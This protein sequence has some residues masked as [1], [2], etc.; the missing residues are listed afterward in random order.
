MPISLALI[1]SLVIAG[2]LLL[3]AEVCVPGM[4]LGIIGFLILAASVALVFAQYGV[5]TGL[6]SA[7]VIG[8]LTLTGFMVWLWIFP[9]T[10]IGRRIVLSS[11]QP[12][13]QTAAENQ[14]LIGATGVAL[15]M[16]RPAGT[17]RINGRRMDVTTSGEFLEE[18]A[19]LIVTAADGMRIVTRRKDGLEAE[20]KA[21]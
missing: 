21:V 1:I 6:I 19:E 12:A 11:S 9:K 10:F 15:T 17:A 3:A 4:I 16:L 2:F 8:G 7:F 5:L 14:E 18:G 13:T 20:P